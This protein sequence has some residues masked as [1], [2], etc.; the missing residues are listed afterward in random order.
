MKIADISLEIYLDQGSP[1]DTC[2][3]VIAHWI[4]GR[5]GTLN[6][7]LFENLTIDPITLELLN[8]GQEVNYEIIAIL[9]KMYK[10]YDFDIQIRQQMSSLANNGVLTATDNG[11]TVTRINRNEVS[12]TLASLKKQ[13]QEDLNSM[14]T[15]YRIKG[16]NPEQVA[17][18]DTFWPFPHFKTE[19]NFSVG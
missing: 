10:I 7:L 11:S 16:A 17:G 12:K 9:K 3:P 19:R 15:S 6:I 18:D 5:I 2:I 14:I 13:E 8:G 4:R 1:T